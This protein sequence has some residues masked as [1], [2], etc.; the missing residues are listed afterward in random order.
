MKLLFWI[1]GLPLL[2][3]AGFFAV[4]NRE[5]VAVSLWP[6]AETLQMPLFLAIAAPFYAGFALGAVIAWGASGRARARAREASRRAAELQRENEALKTR[7]DQLEVRTPPAASSAA[8]PQRSIAG[9]PPVFL[10]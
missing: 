5:T 9:E 1:I 8:P 10:P 6:F 4:A 3:A 7:L 2:L